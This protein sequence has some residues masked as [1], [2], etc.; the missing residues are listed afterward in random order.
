MFILASIY[1]IISA[2]HMMFLNK[3]KDQHVIF[4]GIFIFSGLAVGTNF[5]SMTSFCFEEYAANGFA[6]TF[7]TMMSFGAVGFYICNELIFQR[8]YEVYQRQEDA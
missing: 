7:A 6:Y 4:M 1:A 8:T 3:N 5:V 2:L